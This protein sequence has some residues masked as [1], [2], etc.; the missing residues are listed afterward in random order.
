M[1]GLSQPLGEESKSIE[2]WDMSDVRK[3]NIVLLGRFI[4]ET[5]VRFSYITPNGDSACVGISGVSEL[6]LLRLCGTDLKKE[7][8]EKCIETTIVVNP[9][10]YKD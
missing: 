5:D 10:H 3:G 4:P 1:L 2:F 7:R 9:E 6:V 8:E